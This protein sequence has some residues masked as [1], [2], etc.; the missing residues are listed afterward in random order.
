MFFP[1]AL[2]NAPKSA[3]LTQ[4]LLPLQT[5]EEDFFPISPILAGHGFRQAITPISCTANVHAPLCFH[6]ICAFEMY[7]R[8]NRFAFLCD[9]FIFKALLGAVF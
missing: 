8:Y 9:S 3:A 6:F 5:R 7:R 2:S 4:T 1:V